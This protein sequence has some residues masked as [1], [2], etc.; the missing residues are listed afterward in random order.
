MKIMGLDIGGANTDCTIINIENDKLVSMKNKREYFPMWKNN[1]KLQDCL[2]KFI[3]DDRD[4][5]I[6]CVSMT[7]ELADGYLSKTEGVRDISNKVLEVFDRNKV[8]FVTF[9]GLKKIEELKENYLMAAAANWIGTAE[10]IKYIKKDC[11]FMDIG[12]TTTDIIPIKNQKEIAEG[13]SDLERLISGELIYT[14]MLRTNLA[15]IVHTVPIT[16]QNSRVSSELF[17]ISADMHRILGNISENDY[18]CSTPDNQGKD[19]ISCKRRLARLVCAD[20][21]PL[22]DKE[23]IK[24]AHYIEDKQIE[25]IYEGLKQVHDRTK[26]DTVLVTSIGNA[27]LCEKAA[28]KLNLKVI[29]LEDYMTKK[30]T[31]VLTAIGAIQ[32]YLDT[33]DKK[34]VLMENI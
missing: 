27:A 18:T 28:K 34:I 29:S 7:A 1:D 14:G 22:E 4:I 6:I 21:D 3:I 16:S 9:D 30:A 33:L 8:F 17:T 5:D 2:K 26:I 20:L 11:I 12:S 24:L 15:S 23:I 31:N 25:Q 32:M 10:I 19:I 13:H